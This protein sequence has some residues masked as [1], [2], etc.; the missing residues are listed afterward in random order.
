[1]SV[2]IATVSRLAGAWAELAWAVTWQGALLVGAFALVALGMRR[3]SPGLRYG[4]WQV[5]A[6]KL[7]LMP[8]WGVAIALPAHPRREPGERPRVPPAA[9]SAGTIG[10]GPEDRVGGPG[11]AAS[12]AGPPGESAGDPPWFARIDRPAWLLGGWGLAVAVQVAAIARQRRR[13]ERLLR[14]ASPAGEPDLLALVAELSDRVGLRRRPEVLIVDDEGSPFVCR[15]RRPALVLPRGLAGT[16]DPG[17]LRAVLLHEL[18]HIRRR[19]LVWDWIPVIARLVYFFHPAA[20]YVAYRARLERE[21]ACDQAAMV[22]TGQEADGYASTL[23][24][25]MSRASAPPAVRAALAIARFGGD[26]P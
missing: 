16:L 18:A 20:H 9:R 8:L 24:E 25:V 19:D 5:A 4:L 14:R 12:A 7:L 26:A 1:M 13:L 11:P 10:A 3:S 22:L 23:I 15:P 6:I 21:L 2:D 17:S